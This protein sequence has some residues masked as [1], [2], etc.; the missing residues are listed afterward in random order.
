MSYR[1]IIKLIRSKDTILPMNGLKYIS[2]DRIGD[3]YY[4]IKTNKN[5]I[6][7]LNRLEEIE[8]WNFESPSELYK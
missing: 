8:R 2:V 6:E 7:Y 1:F 3:G 4:K 5:I